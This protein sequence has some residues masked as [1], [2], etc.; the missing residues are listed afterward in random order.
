MNYTES[1]TFQTKSGESFFG[2]YIAESVS[3]YPWGPNFHHKQGGAGVPEFVKV[4]LLDAYVILEIG[5][6]QPD[7]K[8]AELAS[9]ESV[10]IMSALIQNK[11]FGY[12][13]KMGNLVRLLT[14]VEL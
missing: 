2:K 13:D 8:G 14:F 11:W 9:P 4:D 5:M 3:S 1:S 6:F 7:Y 10:S 12:K